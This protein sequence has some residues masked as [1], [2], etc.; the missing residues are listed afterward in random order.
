MKVND[1][2]R[3]FV[4]MKRYCVLAI[5][6]CGIVSSCD[7]PATAAQ[8]DKAYLMVEKIKAHYVS[9]NEPDIAESIFCSPRHNKVIIS[10]KTKK[11]AVGEVQLFAESIKDACG[12]AVVETIFDPR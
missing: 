11:V 9:R 8:V 6:L 1:G 2:R 12:V 5:V 10:V 4:R 7:R 3:P